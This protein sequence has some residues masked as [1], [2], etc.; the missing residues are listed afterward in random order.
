MNMKSRCRW[1]NAFSAYFDVTSGVKQGGVLSPQIFTIYVDELISRLRKS[2]VGCHI[3]STFLAALMYADDLCLI[4][5]TR[6]ALQKLLSICEEFSTDFCLS[7]N[8]KKSKALLFGKTNL[9]V[10]VLTLNDERIEF[11]K[12]W[13]Y[14]GCSIVSGPRL[15]FSVKAE[16]GAFYCASNSVLKSITRP[17][18]LVLMNLLYSHCVPNLTYCA[19]VKELSASI[20]SKCNVALN[21]SIRYIFSYNRWE[22][23]R[24]LRQELNLPNIVE[25][26]HSRRRL[27]MQRNDKSNNPIIRFI[28]HYLTK[29][30]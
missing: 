18:E 8:G 24:Y 29:A 12:I 17:N 3:T 5:P 7:F 11:V 27:F 23:T 28:T 9:S 16:L 30:T 19:E 20:M 14:L 6:S 13:K 2:G 21:D 25:I 22:S 15:S 10:D 1:N 26:F 4:A